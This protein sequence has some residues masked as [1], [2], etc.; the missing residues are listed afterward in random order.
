MSSAFPESNRTQT[1][2]L[3]R[4]VQ[5]LDASGQSLRL[6]NGWTVAGILDPVA[7]WDRQRLYLMR[8]WSAG[9]E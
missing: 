1:E 8:H 2:R 5:R 6:S 4:V 9:A 7:F 3:R